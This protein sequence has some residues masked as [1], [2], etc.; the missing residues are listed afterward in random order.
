MRTESFRLDVEGGRRLA[1]STP[2]VVDTHG[3]GRVEYWFSRERAAA[4]AVL[5]DD[6]RALDAL[7]HSLKNGQLYRW[8]YLAEHDPLY[9]HHRHNP[10]FQAI[11]RQALAHR[12]PQRTLLDEMRREGKVPTRVSMGHISSR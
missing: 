1:A 4:F 8:W 6:D 12:N 5:G 3:V 9:Q 11:N 2:A 10:R 7:A